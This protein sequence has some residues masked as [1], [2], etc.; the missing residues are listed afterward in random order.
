MQP[1]IRLGQILHDRQ[2]GAIAC[3]EDAT[4]ES[5]VGIAEEPEPTTEE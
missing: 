3:D 4:G 5:S 2:F 1:F